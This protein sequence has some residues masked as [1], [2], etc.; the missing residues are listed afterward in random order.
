MDRT[1]EHEPHPVPAI[2]ADPGRPEEQEHH[3]YLYWEFHRQGGKRAVRL[4]DWKAIQ[5]E[6]H[7]D[8]DA[9]LR[10]YHLQQDPAEQH[11]VA[12]EHPAIIAR[13]REIFAEA[14]EPTEDWFFRTQP[15]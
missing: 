4:G 1:P 15:N 3:D 14:H 12:A 8:P 7:R 10:L 2:L 9:P 6:L 11:D 5:L 13:V